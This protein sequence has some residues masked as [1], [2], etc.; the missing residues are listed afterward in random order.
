[1]SRQITIITVLK[2]REAGQ[3][4]TEESREMKETVENSKV[5]ENVR[6]KMLSVEAQDD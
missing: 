3:V 1:M 6:M 4:I 2:G 5:M